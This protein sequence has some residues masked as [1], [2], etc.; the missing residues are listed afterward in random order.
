MICKKLSFPE[1]LD[2]KVGLVSERVETLA[3][4]AVENLSKTQTI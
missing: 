2:L 4:K 3:F 1:V